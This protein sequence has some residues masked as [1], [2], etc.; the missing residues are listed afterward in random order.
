MVSEI[1]ALSEDL[2]RELHNNAKEAREQ[3]NEI[4]R[5]LKAFTQID[6]YDE[7]KKILIMNAAKKTKTSE[8]LDEKINHLEHLIKVLIKGQQEIKSHL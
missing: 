6:G 1:K 4:I 8:P 5:L 3:R 7:Y 2:L